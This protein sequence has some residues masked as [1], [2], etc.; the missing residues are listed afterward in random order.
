MNVL[1]TLFS[2]LQSAR[3]FGSAVPSVSRADIVL[4]N[5]RINREVRFF[6]AQQ[7][8]KKWGV[9]AI[10]TSTAPSGTSLLA[11]ECSGLIRTTDLLAFELRRGVL[12]R[13]D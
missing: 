5:G 1:Q 8:G 12:Q 3:R 10:A 9:R 6:D 4:P 13:R 2:I 11:E 7:V